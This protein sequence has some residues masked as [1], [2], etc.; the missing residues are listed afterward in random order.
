MLIGKDNKLVKEIRGINAGKIKNKFIIEGEVFVKE[1]PSNINLTAIV[2]SENYNNIKYFGDYKNIYVAPEKLFKSISQTMTPQGVFAVCEKTI[3][4]VEDFANDFLLILENIQ[5]PGNMGNMIRSAT[6]FGVDAVL[7]SK[8]CVNIYNP[9]VIRSTAG[10]IFKIP[11]IENIDS[12]K[13]IVDLQ[14]KGFKIIA[15]SPYAKKYF[16]DIDMKNNVAIVMGNEANGIS[17]ELR[18]MCDLETKIPIKNLE[19]LNVSVA[20]GIMLHEVLKQRD[21]S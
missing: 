15:T 19:S 13:I 7:V 10:S 11:I 17:K 12:K 1:I 6:C 4:N 8:N 5:D 3:Y 16:F 18:D 20:C 2:V 21:Y 14:K 9:K